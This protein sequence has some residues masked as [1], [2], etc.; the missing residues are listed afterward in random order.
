MAGT[1]L[2]D[3][4]ALSLTANAKSVVAAK[5]TDLPGLIVQAERLTGE[6]T[7]ILKQIVA[8]HPTT[9]GDATNSAS[10]TAIIAE[11]A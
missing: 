3:L 5:G 11:L 2:T 9:G 7:V 10:L 1:C 4:K 8:L 6:L